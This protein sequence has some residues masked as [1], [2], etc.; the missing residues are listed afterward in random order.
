[1]KREINA[2]SLVLALLSM[3]SCSSDP[4]GPAQPPTTNPT[5]SEN[6]KLEIRI[7][8]SVEETR[9]TDF[10]YESGDQIGLF[11]V[12]YTGSTAGSLVNSGNHVDNMRFTYNGQ[13]N[14][15]S[16]IYW[17]DNDTHAD[18]YIYYPYSSVQ[19]V[20]AHPFAVKADQSSESGYKASDF[21]CGRVKNV[22]PTENATVIPS[23]HVMSRMVINLQAGNGF[24]NESLAASDVA[25]KINGVKCNSTVNIATGV[26]TPTG[27]AVTVTPWYTENAYKALIVPQ[28]VAEGNLITV[29]VDGRDFNLKKGFTFESGKSHKFTVTLS[30]TSSGVNVNITPWNEDGVDN[31]GTAE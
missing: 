13:W 6:A 15:D 14:P 5:P 17:K 18:F 10:G 22:A 16:P 7:S 19:S 8:P 29:T 4:E 2:L 25:V 28:T 3:S 26:V 31:G 23:N 30:K 20:S 11:V 24:T 27:D 1:M 12:N 21:M 9:A